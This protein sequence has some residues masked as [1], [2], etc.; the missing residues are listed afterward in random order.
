MDIND[1]KTF[2]EV[3][4]T[5]HFGQAAA[6]LFITQ[7]TVSS[8]IRNLEQVL[9]DKLFIRE[10]NNLQLTP[11]GEKLVRYAVMIT[12]AWDRVQ[13]E[14]GPVSGGADSISIGG[15]PSLWPIAIQQ[16]MQNF[17][18]DHPGFSV[19]AE[20][21]NHDIIHKR[22]INNTLDVAFVYDPHPH[23]R[24]EIFPMPPVK[25]VMV[26]S[27]PAIKTLQDIS[28]NYLVVDWGSS[29]S[30]KHTPLLD[31]IQATIMHF[32]SEGIALQFLLELGGTAYLALPTAAEYLQRGELFKIENAPEIG[33][34]VY[35][36]VNKYN[37]RYAMLEG[38]LSA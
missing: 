5:R 34:N 33:R 36:M 16:W 20:M 4:R 37:D 17:Y 21:L 19:N 11:A 25:L 22:I 3:N 27:D 12:S 9:G 35:A 24:I 18:S 23:D 31:E 28:K 8:R 10:R 38:L 1:L 13:Q 15:I 32:N 6:N 30:T 7:S 14:M 2:L 29:F 26:T